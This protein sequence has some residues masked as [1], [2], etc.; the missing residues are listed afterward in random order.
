MHEQLMFWPSPSSGEWSEPTALSRDRLTVMS[1]FDGR[2][3]EDVDLAIELVLE[4]RRRRRARGER[5]PASSITIMPDGVTRFI[6]EIHPEEKKQLERD[7]WPGE[8]E[9]RSSFESALEEVSKTPAHG[10]PRIVV[11][12]DPSDGIPIETATS[13]VNTDGIEAEDD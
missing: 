11:E 13:H 3:D 10:V 9:E 12:S 4:L 7:G 8:F 5:A 1:K 6:L 2:P